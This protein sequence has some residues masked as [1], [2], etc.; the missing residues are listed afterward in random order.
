MEMKH[1]FR[2]GLLIGWIIVSAA[3]NL[4]KPEGR[5]DETQSTKPTATRTLEP[6]PYPTPTEVEIQGT[7]RIWHSWNEPE[8]ISLAQIIDGFREIYPDVY[9]DV[10]YIPVEDIQARYGFETQ[11]GSGPTLLLGPAEWGP[12]LFEA[13]LIQDLKGALQS[14]IIAGV[15]KPAMGAA[16]YKEALI[17]L[18]YAIQ[19]IVLY[20]NKEIA[21][22]SPKTL[23]ELITMAQTATQGEDVGTILERSYFYSGAH[24]NGIDGQWMDSDGMPTFNNERGLAWIELLRTFEQAGPVNFMTDQD[25]EYFES[26]RVGWIIDGTWNMQTLAEALGAEKLAIDPWPICEYG[27]LSGYVLPDNFFLSSRA[28]GNN[29]E[30]A[31]KF[32]EYFLSPQA[33]NNLSA[34]GRIPAISNIQLTDSDTSSLIT[35]AMAALAEGTAY[36]VLPVM[37]IYNM[38]VDV[39][40]RAIF[41]EGVPPAQALQNAEEAIQAAIQQGQMTPTP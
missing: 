29:R 33:Q 32:I 9:F 40:L 19:G 15:N 28:E 30:A 27:R 8:R 41:E 7:V 24:L 3:C 5:N 22:L 2:L 26:G 17:G 31:I 16:Y 20:R 35:Q 34:V 14:S 36:P 18:P 37:S 1:R 23:D 39:A 38:N 6:P 10:L 11:E 25:I 13:N 12:A 21:T 4:P